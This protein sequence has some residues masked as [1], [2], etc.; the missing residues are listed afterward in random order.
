MDTYK[1]KTSDIPIGMDRNYLL[2]KIEFGSKNIAISK[3]YIS[4][5]T[6]EICVTVVKKWMAKSTF[7]DFNVSALLQK[8][9]LIEIHNG[10]NF[11]SKSFYFITASP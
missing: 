8:L 7:F 2:E 4:N 10:F 5:A 6:G 3:T 1:N 9:G 11:I